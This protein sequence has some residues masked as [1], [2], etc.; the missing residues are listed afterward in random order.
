MAVPGFPWRMRLSHEGLRSLK[1]ERPGRQLRVDPVD[2]VA[3]DDILVLTGSWPEQ[4]EAAAAQVR[5][6]ARP[7][8][9]ASPEVL[10][11]LAGLGPLQA[12]PGP[13]SVDGLALELRSYA[14]IPWLSPAE[15]PGKLMSAAVRPDRALGRLRARARLPRAA[16]LAFQLTLPDGGR[17]VFLGTALHG[18]TSPEWLAQVKASWGRPEWLVVGVDLGHEAAAAR[19]IPQIGAEHVVLTDL[20]S[21][22]RRKVGLKV[23]LLTPLCDTLIEAGVAAQVLVSG[24]GLRFERA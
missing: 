15:A 19:L 20:V 13:V 11:Y 3:P 12:F 18:G 7:T 8:V 9:V 10:A 4:L 16:P 22:V 5:G 21:E 23:G 14:P 6:G 17:L 24:A 1:I 2:P